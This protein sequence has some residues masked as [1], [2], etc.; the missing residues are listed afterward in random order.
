MEAVS[1]IRPHF[2]SDEPIL[3]KLGGKVLLHKV[4][5]PLPDMRVAVENWPLV[6]RRATIAP[7]CDNHICLL[8]LARGWPSARVQ[9][10]AGVLPAP[11]VGL[12]W[13]PVSCP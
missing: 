7:H 12:A 10:R 4:V 8:K 9:V 1:A 2:A 13:I 6:R 5:V 3:V 11:Y